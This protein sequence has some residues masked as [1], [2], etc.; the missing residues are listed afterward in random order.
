MISQLNL[1]KNLS[2]DYASTHNY[3]YSTQAATYYVSGSVFVYNILAK[4]SVAISKL[5]L[6]QNSVL[7]N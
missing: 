3:A 4:I 6:Q 2:G 7:S 5:I 1:L